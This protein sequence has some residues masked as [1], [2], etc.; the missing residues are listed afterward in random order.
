MAEEL[1]DRDLLQRLVTESVE[2]RKLLQSSQQQVE[3]MMAQ[4]VDLK[5][6]TH[7][8]N[9]QC[10]AN[11]V[12]RG[13]AGNEASQGQGSALGSLPLTTNMAVVLC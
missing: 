11:E 4:L 1:S 7:S 13:Q 8:V 3:R 9:V 10:A 6:E 12:S 2:S 5:L